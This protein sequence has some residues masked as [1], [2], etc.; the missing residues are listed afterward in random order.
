[1]RVDLV[2]LIAAVALVFRSSVMSEHELTLHQD[3][4]ASFSILL[5]AIWCLSVPKSCTSS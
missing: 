5:C 3:F 1:M 2:F 4:E